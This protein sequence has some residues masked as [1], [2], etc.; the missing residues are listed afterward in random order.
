MLTSLRESGIRISLDD[1]GTGFSSLSYLSRLPL[2]KI[3]IDKSF[4]QH[5]MDDTPSRAVT[6]AIITLGQRL[7]LEIVAEGIE[8]EATLEIMHQLGCHQAQ[9]FYI[10]VPERWTQISKWMSLPQTSS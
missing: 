3:K 5:V 1:F 9:G 8:D 10:G 2:D 4:I 6:E 7:N